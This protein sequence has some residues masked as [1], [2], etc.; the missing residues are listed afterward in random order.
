MKADFHMGQGDLFPSM[1][2]TLLDE[3]DEPFPIP[4]GSTVTLRMR[5]VDRS[6]PRITG[7]VVVVDDGSAAK[8]GQTRHDWVAGET[9]IPGLYLVQVLVNTAGRPQS[10]ANTDI[11]TL[12]IERSV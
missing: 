1:A 9:D 10:F 2:I 4:P 6:R 12:W 7:A 5:L 11:S 8:A 3:D